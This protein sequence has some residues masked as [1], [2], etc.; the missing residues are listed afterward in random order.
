MDLRLAAIRARTDLC[1]SK[2]FRLAQN[3]PPEPNRRQSREAA[4]HSIGCCII[5]EKR[6]DLYEFSL[7]AHEN[8]RGKKDILAQRLPKTQKPAQ[9]HLKKP[10]EGFSA[11]AA[12]TFS[13]YKYTFINGQAAYNRAESFPQAYIDY[14]G[15]FYEFKSVTKN[16]FA[17]INEIKIPGIAMPGAEALHVALLQTRR[18][19]EQNITPTPFVCREIKPQS[20]KKYELTNNFRDFLICFH[21]GKTKKV[22]ISIAQVKDTSISDNIDSEIFRAITSVF[23]NQDAEIYR[24]LADAL[25]P[26][27]RMKLFGRKQITNQVLHKVSKLPRAGFEEL[28]DPSKKTKLWSN[29]IT[30]Y[31]SNGQ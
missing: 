27:S 20:G 6:P 30:E 5:A 18:E 31:Q 21:L 24:T 19:L 11:T 22:K 8:L 2:I 29:I 26:A 10:P 4:P 23:R 25:L 16:R 28:K 3:V 12:Y 15:T 9:E 17:L 1:H 13:S 7:E 14:R